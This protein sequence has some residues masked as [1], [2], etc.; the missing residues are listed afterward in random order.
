MKRLFFI[1]LFLSNILSAQL[2]TFVYEIKHKPNPDKEI[3]ETGNYYLDVIGGQ[4]AFR[5]EKERYADSLMLKN[6]YW[7]GGPKTS[8]NQLYIIKNLINKSITKSITTLSMHDLYNIPINDK[9][10]WEILPER[11]KIGDMECQKATVK[12]GERNWIAWFSQSIPLLEGPYIFH[13]LP[14][15]IIKI[16]DDKNDYDFSLIKTINVDKNKTFYLRKGKEISWETYE[17]IQSDYYSDPFA[18]IKAR[19][20]KYKVT[21]E[22][23]NPVEM[24]LK[25]MTES[26]QKQIKEN[27]NPIELN[28]KVNY[29]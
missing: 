22:K 14:G 9:L 3:F 2:V 7:E 26:I 12:Y 8:L 11:M 25:Q 6:G 18:E 5:S 10:N 16:S 19:N 1:M 13:G 29:N 24:N 21:D 28:H 17:K 4:S 23:G 20:I 27:N 15:L